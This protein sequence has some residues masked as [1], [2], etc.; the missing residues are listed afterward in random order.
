[1]SIKTVTKIVGTMMASMGKAEAEFEGG[2]D[3]W[4]IVLAWILMGG[5]S[6]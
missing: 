2:F 1:M 5:S 4:R 6:L 3:L